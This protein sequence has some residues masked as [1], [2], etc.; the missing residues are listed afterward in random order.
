MKELIFTLT[1]L[2]ALLNLSQSATLTFSTFLGSP[3]DDINSDFCIDDSGFIYI[4]GETIWGG[5]PITTGSFDTT[6]N[7]GGSGIFP[8]YDIFITKMN[9]DGSSLIFSTYLGGGLE[10]FSNSIQIDSAKSVYVCGFNFSGDF[11]VTLGA[12][13]TNYNFG[14]LTKLNSTG[15]SLVYSTFL[16][17]NLT[18]YLN[19]LKV[20]KQGFA[21]LT[22]QTGSEIII[23]SKNKKNASI[24][25]LCQNTFPST[26]G[27][28]DECSD[29]SDVFLTKI[30][31]SGSGLVFS[32]FLG[33]SFPETAYDLTIET[34]GNSYLTGSTGSNDFPI[35]SNV[36]DSSYNN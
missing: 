11:P 9:P 8:G 3:S 19:S 2:L 14:F 6:Y 33:G 4:T 24:D 1:I 23:N 34:N 26:S 30:N 28:Y 27:V 31:Q 22:G 32:T 20:N 7:P 25:T 12:F 17:G 13:Q 15:S 35:T 36:F 10:D 21:Y 5:F 29:E 18:D 16:G